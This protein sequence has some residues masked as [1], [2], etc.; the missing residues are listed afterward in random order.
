MNRSGLVAATAAGLLVFAAATT[1]APSPV[2]EPAKAAAP[3]DTPATLDPGA[4]SGGALSSVRRGR[5]DAGQLWRRQLAADASQAVMSAR[6][7][8]P[9]SRVLPP[10][11]RFAVA[12]ERLYAFEPTAERFRAAVEGIEDIRAAAETSYPKNFGYD[13][14]DPDL[15]RLLDIPAQVRRIVLHYTEGRR[16]DLDGM[17]HARLMS[18]IGRG[19]GYNYYL[20]D[21]GANATA[22]YTSGQFVYHILGKNTDA[23]G[24]EVA[25]CSQADIKAHQWEQLLYLVAHFMQA[26]DV[27][28]KD[29]PVTDIVNRFVVGHREYARTHANLDFPAVITEPFRWRLIAFLVDELGFPP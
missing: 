21:D 9:H 27:V 8:C 13:P 29:R 4:P 15:P 14:T 22:Y 18:R 20:N 7:Y 10:K 16:D 17:A 2:A 24:V 26:N 6:G 3:G 28:G 1:V 19:T 11:D 5:P 23:F 12:L 25:A